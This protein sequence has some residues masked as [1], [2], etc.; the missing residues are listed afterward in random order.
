MATIVGS[1][2]KEFFLCRVAAGLV[3]FETYWLS[4][5]LR[6]NVITSAAELGCR[7]GV[8]DIG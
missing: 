4:E 5:R 1:Y 7:A 6:R 8:V 2:T 3:G